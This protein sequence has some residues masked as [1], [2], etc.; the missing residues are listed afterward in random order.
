MVHFS[1]SVQVAPLLLLPFVENA[2]KHGVNSQGQG[3]VKFQLSVED[4]TIVF[5]AQNSIREH[6][7]LPQGESGIGLD[8]VKRRLAHFYPN[9]HHLKLEELSEAFTVA[10]RISI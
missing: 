1:P 6:R 7:Q 3:W 5:N 4:E 10:L 9:K 2:F 8:N